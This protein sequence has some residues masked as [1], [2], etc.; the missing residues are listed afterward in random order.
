M[1][2]P[3]LTTPQCSRRGALARVGQAALTTVLP[4]AALQG[5][6]SSPVKVGFFGG[7]TGPTADLGIAGR[8][9]TLLA[10]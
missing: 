2:H 7:L 5:C 8:D 3:G 6:S 9:S 1:H 10:V 4:W